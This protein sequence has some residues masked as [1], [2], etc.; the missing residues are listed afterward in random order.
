MEN[1]TQK[2]ESTSFHPAFPVSLSLSLYLSY[3]LAV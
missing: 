3:V 1:V 2:N